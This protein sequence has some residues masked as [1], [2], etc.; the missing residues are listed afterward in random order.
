MNV[1]FLSFVNVHVS[2]LGCVSMFCLAVYKHW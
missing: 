2:M 1:P